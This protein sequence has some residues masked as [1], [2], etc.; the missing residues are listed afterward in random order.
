MSR[1]RLTAPGLALSAFLV[2]LLVVSAL[3]QEPVVVRGK[4]VGC[5]DG[6]SIT[7]LTPQKAQIKVCLAFLDA[8]EVSIGMEARLGQAAVRL[9]QG[10]ADN[11]TDLG[12]TFRYENKRYS[13]IGV[14]ELRQREKAAG[15][16]DQGA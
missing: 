8:P 9:R 2:L 11:G 5:Y 4:V 7:V 6:D 16:N 12:L 3:G 13:G 15:K 14:G 10:M 1:R